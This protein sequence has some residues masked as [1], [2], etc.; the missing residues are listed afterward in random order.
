L[1]HYAR[2]G[3][4]LLEARAQVAHGSWS[5][6]LKNNFELSQNTAIRYMRLARKVEVDPKFTARG[7]NISLTSAIVE[8][9][10]RSAW[11]TVHQATE[12]INVE[13]LV[14]LFGLQ[15][16]AGICRRNRPRRDAHELVQPGAGLLDRG[17]PVR[18]LVLNH[19]H[20]MANRRI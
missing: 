17:S 20:S 16:S 6:W 9:R 4:M 14:N 11:K 18:G 13:R 1:E 3:E 2:A 8:I 10:A 12:R 15:R 19:L 5:R 7:E